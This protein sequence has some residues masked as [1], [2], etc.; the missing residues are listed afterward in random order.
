MHYFLFGKG[1]ISEFS[2]SLDNREDT[3]L[4]LS[5]YGAMVAYSVW[6]WDVVG[7]S[8]TTQTKGLL[9]GI[10][11][12]FCLRNRS[13]WVRVSGNPPNSP[14]SSIFLYSVISFGILLASGVG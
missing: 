11:I 6:N 12:P 7:S 2:Y 9:K 14:M 10:G 13:L 3:N 5:A 1:V 4:T 8:P